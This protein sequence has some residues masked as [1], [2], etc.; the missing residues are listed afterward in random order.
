MNAEFFT[1]LRASC[2]QRKIPLI[3]P[4]SQTL[5]QSLLEK[6]QPKRCLEIGAAVGYSSMI[7]AH[8]IQKRGWT[9]TSFEV[10][11]PSY[12]E[13]QHYIHQQKISNIMLYPFDITKTQSLWDL[14]PRKCDF[15]F[16]DAQ[17]SQYGTYL[18]KIQA[19]LSPENIVLL[20]DILKY[21]TKL[22]WLYEFLNKNQINYEILPSEEWDAMML[23][24]NCPTNSAS[25][26]LA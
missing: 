2:I 19:Y 16:I 20:D 24:K 6:Y 18:E 14:F 25:T 13:A 26:L 3:S 10:A 17:K 8:T 15:V 22:T 5:L 1:Q 21:Q 12:L 23:I 7:I 4:E 11:Y 9:L